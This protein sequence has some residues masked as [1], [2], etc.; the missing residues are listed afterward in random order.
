MSCKPAGPGGQTSVFIRGTNSNHV[1]VL[2]DGIEVSDPTNSNRSFDFGNLLTA[3]IERIEVLRGPQSG[4]YGADAIGGVISITTKKGNG[5]PKISATVEGGSFGTFNQSA[6]LSGSQDRFNYAFNVVHLRST[7]TPVTPDRI[8]L[9]GQRAFDN[10][11]DNQTYSSKLGADLNENLSLNWVGRYTDS[12]L[13]FT[14]GAVNSAQSRTDLNQ[15]F[16]RGEAVVTLFDGRFKNYFG[17]N[18]GD[19]WNSTLAPSSPIESVNKGYRTAQ[20]WRGVVSVLPGQTV[21]VGFDHY[22]ESMQSVTSTNGNRGGYV[23]LQSEFAK[24]LFLVANVRRDSNDSFGGYTTYRIAPAA[25]IPV[26]ETK[27][28]ASYGTGFKPPSLFQLFANIPFFMGNPNLRPET[29]KGYDFGFEQPL[30]NDRF[31]FG[32]TRYGNKIENLI[33]SDPTFTTLVNVDQSNI[34]GYEA[35]AAL[36]VNSQLSFRTDYTYT[37][38]EATSDL[39][40]VRR[41]PHKYSVTALWSPIMP[42]QLSATVVTTSGWRDLDRVT[43]ATIDQPGYAT[44]NLAANYQ[45]NE[46]VKAFGRIDNLFN[47]HYENPNGF[48]RPGLGAYAGI[49]VANR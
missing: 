5:P 9:P 10:S 7:N 11:Y 41:P 27:L 46:N 37:R 42:L 28:K 49:S 23:E 3:D 20:D 47:R 44:V 38:I 2:I 39:A 14:Q 40:I 19:Y 48:L 45:I 26:T 43:F 12:R 36:A 8:L 31:R 25:I 13:F 22:L 16:T 21:V 15:F 32:L 34:R 1:K 4:L 18:Y 6:N 24:R 33:A 29:S 17:V 30:F 35:F